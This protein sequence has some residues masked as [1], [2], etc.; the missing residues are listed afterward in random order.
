MSALFH[1][2]V[3]AIIKQDERILLLKRYSFDGSLFWDAPGGR[4]D[5]GEGFDEAIRRELT[6][7]IGFLGSFRKGDVLGVQKWGDEGYDGPD[8]ILIYF[9]VEAES[10]T[11]IKLSPEHDSFRWV[12]LND[13]EEAA[14]E[15][16]LEPELKE[17]LE[18]ALIF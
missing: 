6:E 10:V 9:S 2:A 5:E 14:S 11:E 18:K 7:E 15:C 16:R 13:M 1:I 8:K 4:L 12:G 17:V 3:K